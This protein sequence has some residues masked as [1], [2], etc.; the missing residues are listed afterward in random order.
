MASSKSW[1]GD[2]PCPTKTQIE[3]ASG[4][5]PTANSG[6]S[7]AGCNELASSRYRITVVRR[8]L[9]KKAEPVGGSRF[10]PLLPRFWAQQFCQTHDQDN[11]EVVVIFAG[12]KFALFPAG[13][14]HFILKSPGRDR[15]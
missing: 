14:F 9:K 10:L 4:N 5:K 1:K 13:I 7:D 6:P 11:N 15:K 2:I 12:G 8:H 3:N